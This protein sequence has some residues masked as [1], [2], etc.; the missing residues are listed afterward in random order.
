[1]KSLKKLLIVSLMVPV[2][3]T[4]AA[5]DGSVGATSTGTS[6]LTVIIPKLIRI[7]NVA[8]LNFGTYTG[9][10]DLNQNDDVNIST[11]YGTAARTYRVTATGSGAA[12]AF[13]VTDG[14]STIAYNVYW[15]DA[16]GTSGEVALTSGTPLTA[17]TGAVKPLSTATNN[18]NFHGEFLEANLQAVDAA[19]YTGT[20]TMVVTPE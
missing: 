14:T 11:N 15:N 2:C 19:T 1:M 6:T 12:S 8:D 13:T 20:L 10:G 9:T 5:T 3:S 7:R 4:Y 17:Q 18:A 16:T